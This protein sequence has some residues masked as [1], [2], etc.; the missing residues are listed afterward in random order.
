MKNIVSSA[1]IAILL[2]VLLNACKKQN[3]DPLSQLP[4]ATQTGQNTFACLINGQPNVYHDDWNFEGGSSFSVISSNTYLFIG[5]YDSSNKPQMGLSIDTVSSINEGTTY[6]L[7]NYNVRGY[8]SGALNYDVFKQD[9]YTTT[10]NVTGSL[11]LTKYSNALVNGYQR[12]VTS[13][14]FYF[15]AVN[16]KGDTVKVT[17]GRVDLLQQ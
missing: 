3:I 13:G 16:A 4:P 15:N 8:A 7:S 6:K 2:V 11:T 14:T 9:Y 1:I 17:N 12:M 5:I 10:A